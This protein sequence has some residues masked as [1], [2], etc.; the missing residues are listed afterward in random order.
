MRGLFDPTE[1]NYFNAAGQYANAFDA[2]MQNEQMQAST[3]SA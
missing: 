1:V 2:L 3:R